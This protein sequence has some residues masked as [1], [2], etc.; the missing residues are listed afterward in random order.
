MLQSGGGLVLMLQRAIAL[1]ACAFSATLAAAAPPDAP[2]VSVPDG[3]EVVEFADDDLAH[4][5]FSMTLDA[6]GLVAVSGPG[7]VRLL[8]DTNGD[9]V[10]D[11]AKQFAAGPKTGAQGMYFHGRSLLCVGDEGLLRYRDQDGDGQAD[12]PPDVLLRLKTGGEHDA[13]SIQL[14]PDGWWYLIAG[15]T[16]NIT[17][18][19]A[20]L[21]TSPVKQPRAG[22]I[23]RFKPD[24]SA[25]EILADGLRNAYDFTFHS[26][27]DLLTFDSDDERDVSLPWYRP[28]RVFLT[29]TGS[30]HG[31][32]SRSWKRPNYFFDMPPV[33]G[34]FGRGSPTGLVSYRH[35][36]FPGEYR[37]AVFALDWTYGRVFCLK[38]K[39]SGAAWSATSEVFM[40]GKDGYGFAPTD[41]EVGPDGSLYV[42][43]GGRGTRGAVY[44]V[45]A[46][47]AG[48]PPPT[49][50][51]P[52]EACLT[53]P[54]PLASW[55]RARWTPQARS[56]GK[57]PFVAAALDEARPVAD[58]VRAIEIVTELFGGFDPGTVKQLNTALSS[59]VRARAIWSHGRTSGANV[60]S[61]L[62]AL[63][64]DDP[65]PYVARAALEVAMNL[66]STA[67]WQSLHRPLAKRLGGS[68]RFNRSLAA[69]IV[70][71]MPEAE[72][73]KLSQAATQDGPRAV[74]SYSA[75]WLAHVGTD[76]ARV[77]RAMSPVAVALL[78]GDYPP[79]LKIDALRLVQWMLG[80][81]APSD[82]HPPAFDGYAPG[83]DPA[84]L[85]RD[86]DDLRV[87]LADLYPTGIGLVDTE[88]SRVL[89]MLAP[90]NQKLLDRVLAPLT[91]ESDPIEDLHQLL[92]AAR[93]PVPRTTDQRQKIA[94]GLVRI[95]AKFTTRSLPQ[96]SA[97]NDRLRDLFTRLC[98]LD[99]FLAPVM[100]D[101]PGFG[102][103]GHVLF[104]SQ[105]PERRLADA[106]GAFVKQIEANPQYP[107]NN[108]VIFVLGASDNPAHWE[109]LRKQYARFAVQGA[110]LMTLAEQPK[111]RDRPWFREGLDSS[112][113]EVIAA[114]LSALEQLPADK[115]PEEQ[116]ALLRA[117][118]RLGQ[119]EREF[120]ARERVIALLERNTGQ[121][122]PF[123]TGKPGYR[124]QRETIAAW[125]DWIERQWPAATASALGS[126]ESELVQLKTMLSRVNWATGDAG[127]GAQLYEKRA[128]T[129]CHG[130]RNALGPDLSGIAGRFSRED[131]FVAIAIPSRDV[132]ARYQTTIIQTRDGRTFSGLIVYEAVDGLLLRNAQHQTFRIETADI[133]ERRQ[134]PVSLMPVGLLKDLTPADYADLY[135]YLATLGRTSPMTVTGAAARREE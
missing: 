57:P 28:T 42:S 27:G 5:I 89:A 104:M 131:L 100:V 128:C 12:G 10:A 60:Q 68:D 94:E 67:D 32:V 133:E 14:G 118:R 53:A 6:Q 58:R 82:R 44:R 43:V 16:A 115:G 86:W 95:D 109:L 38:L 132:S 55:S 125:T 98:E 9:G 39:P 34:S 31:W 63:F 49:P 66:G 124:P 90:A 26:S 51:A 37:D 47:A 102:R 71:R 126:T 70:A 52:L 46:K 33:L 103:P 2:P 1:S 83:I 129:Q 116:L 48:D 17:A 23:L 56:L 135:A 91:A 30:D 97:W 78:Q 8:L 41:C 117:L 112:Q 19:Y 69:A 84:E 81:L 113:A 127:R 11:Q 119:D 77:R 20:S 80:D 24:L 120:A 75:G 40:T 61:E 99:E 3:F 22:A 130:G 35:T 25:A 110:I 74:V 87:K 108:D 111:P 76:L 45:R 72:L 29:L 15:N 21:P 7:Y 105:M 73:P 85:E 13:H 64:L 101:V 121:Q 50:A 134:S 18:A 122:F 114:C 107:W 106:I 79:E 62:V 59:E 123:V 96:D 36:Q 93:L 4:D 88:L 65:D 92:V 54:Q